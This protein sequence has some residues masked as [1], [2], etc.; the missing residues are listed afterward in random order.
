MNEGEQE[1]TTKVK[2]GVENAEHPETPS[3]SPDLT[4]EEL[5][6]E[7]MAEEEFISD[8]EDEIENPLVYGDDKKLHLESQLHESEVDEKEDIL[9]GA[10][11]TGDLEAEGLP[12]NNEQAL[13]EEKMNENNDPLK[14]D[15]VK[16]PEQTTPDMDFGA[17]ATDMQMNTEA[18]EGED[19]PKEEAPINEALS[20]EMDAML[21]AAGNDPVMNMGA[22]VTDAPVQ[23]V[24]NEMIAPA[25][26]TTNEP[27]AEQSANAEAPAVDA[28]AENATA[29]STPAAEA[30]PTIADLAANPSA[31]TASTDATA[32]TKGKK[33]TGLIIGLAIAAVAVIGGGVGAIAYLNWHESPEQT[34]ADAISNVWNAKNIQAE[35]TITGEAKDKNSDFSKIELKMNMIATQNAASMSIN[36]LSIDTKENGSYSLSVES[37]Y[38]LDDDI[39]FKIGGIKEAF[40]GA[41]K[42]VDKDEAEELE[43]I[44]GMVGGVIEVLDNQWIKIDSDLLKEMG[45]KDQYDCYKEKAKALSSEDFKKKVAEIY[46][47]HGFIALK[48]DKVV[49]TEDGLSYYSIKIDDKESEAFGEEVEKLDEVKAL[50]S[51][52]DSELDT[53]DDEDDEW[54]DDLDLEFNGGIKEDDEDEQR[55]Y[56]LLVGISGWSHTLKAVEVKTSDDDADMSIKLNLS[57]DEKAVELPGDA[58][59]AKDLVEELEKAIQSSALDLV[60]QQV[61]AQ[62]GLM[63]DSEKEIADCVET[64]M[65]ENADEIEE[66]L[67]GLDLIDMFDTIDL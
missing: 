33:K 54:D 55:D 45:V 23:P 21:N 41:M 26:E 13:R 67:G 15:S 16:N 63:Y 52:F 62:C 64:V 11:G 27:T 57:Y 42:N 1:D 25:A 4:L 18:P 46:E 8:K 50:T 2:L 24:E 12:F 40:D 35:A 56:D 66:G 65:E 36:T 6:A 3:G 30:A 51:C 7:A 43:T 37:A 29:E 53:D 5:E 34:L 19:T 20:A 32:K 58:K 17:N 61:T 22:E 59:N 44:S 10:I 49:K 60:K 47:N 9:P 38:S 39:Y 48:D 14:N 28:S 31:N